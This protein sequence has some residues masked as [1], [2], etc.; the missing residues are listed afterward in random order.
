MYNPSEKS[1]DGQI[2]ALFRELL[3][4]MNESEK[5]RMY[6]ELEMQ[7]ALAEAEAL[8]GNV[9]RNTLTMQDFVNIVRKVRKQH[10]WNIA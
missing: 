7:K 6:K 4:E 10:G 9:Q 8:K 1:I 2:T 3:S 5:K